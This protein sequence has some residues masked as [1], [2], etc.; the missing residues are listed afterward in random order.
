L[1]RGVAERLVAIVEEDAKHP[2]PQGLHDLA[3]HFDL[4]FLDGDDALPT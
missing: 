3:L 1:P 4:L 2:V